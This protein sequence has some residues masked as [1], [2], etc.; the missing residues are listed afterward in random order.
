MVA[1]ALRA[2]GLTVH[3]LA[4]LYGGERAQRVA[5]VEWLT[6][7]GE[8]GWAVLMKDDSIRRRPAELEALRAA[9]VKAFCV[10]N[11]GLTGQQ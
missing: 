6:L 7:A 4:S 5:D 8:R 1:E 9:A 2:T 11:A 3:T 10:T